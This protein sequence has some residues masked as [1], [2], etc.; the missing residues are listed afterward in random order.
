MGRVNEDGAECKQVNFYE[1]EWKWF[2]LENIFLTYCN[3]S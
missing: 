3:T 1:D 2:L